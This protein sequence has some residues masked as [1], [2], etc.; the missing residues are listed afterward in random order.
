MVSNAL[1]NVLFY[2]FLILQMPDPIVKLNQLEYNS[3]VFKVK[4]LELQ[5]VD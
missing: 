2:L 5:F 1:Q 3:L 4:F